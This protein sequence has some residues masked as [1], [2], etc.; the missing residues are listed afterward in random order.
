MLKMKKFVLAIA[1]CL[2]IVSSGVATASDQE[3]TLQTGYLIYLACY[4]A[5]VA[6]A[7]TGT[8]CEV[9]I[10]AL[11]KKEIEKGITAGLTEKEFM[12]FCK[13]QFQA[14]EAGSA[15]ARKLTYEEFKGVIAPGR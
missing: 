12:D 5:G 7:G 10:T 9:A 8:T 13:F 11:V 4:D 6:I 15:G 1:C 3:T 2:L 14:C